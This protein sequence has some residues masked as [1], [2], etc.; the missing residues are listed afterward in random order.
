MGAGTH[1][2]TTLVQLYLSGP[3][4]PTAIAESLGMTTASVTGLLDRL[5]AA[6][7]V[8]RSPNPHDRRSVLVR[9]TAEGESAARTIFELFT[10]DVTAALTGTGTAE[11]DALVLLIDQLTVALRRSSTKADLALRLT[12]DP[13]KDHTGAVSSV[14]EKAWLP[15]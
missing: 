15:D 1:E 10:E 6:G 9:L 12:A 7:Q 3:L 2:T 8:T 13:R 14:A 5:A 4:T 11:R